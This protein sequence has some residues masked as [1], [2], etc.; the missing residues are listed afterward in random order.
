MPLDP[1]TPLTWRKLLAAVARRRLQQVLRPLR[2]TRLRRRRSG[3]PN[4]LI[5]AVDTLRYDHLGLAG[6]A[7]AATPAL[8]ALAASGTLFADVMAPA[9]WTLPSFTS[10]L[11]GVMP[12]LHGAGLPGAVRNMDTQP[13]RRLPPEVPTLAQ[14]LAGQ[15]YRTAAFYANPFF[16]FGL[17]ESFQVHAYANLPAT[18]LA[19]RALEW[20][21]RHGERP[22]F[23]FVLFN[24]PHEPTLP[25]ARH[26]RP[27]LTELA[28]RDIHP[29]GRQLRALARWGGGPHS[30][31]LGRTSTP[32]TREAEAALAIKLA[33][34]DAAVAAVDACVA[35][36]LR[37]LARWDLDAG[38]LV[39]VY[40]D[41]GEEFL[42]HAAAARLWNHDPRDIRAI[43]HGH[44]QFQELLHVPWLAAGPG[45]AAGVRRTEPVSLCDVAPT[46]AD[47]LG[48]AP[49]PLPTTSTPGLV[50]RSVTATGPEGGK[51][52]LLAEQ[53]AYG[54]DLVAVRR[55]RWKLL[56]P[57]QGEPLALFNLAEDRRERQDKR[58]EAPAALADLAA[59]LAVWR[60]AVPDG[61]AGPPAGGWQ[62]IS[63][64]V[65]RRLREL[66]YTG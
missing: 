52:L 46:L 42:D 27:F 32:L 44:S 34:Y 54:P 50:G 33:L 8:D 60:S 62:D 23:C 15:G 48:V 64:T 45:I 56:G 35:G 13:P 16:A 14:H 40:S 10:S 36:V 37:Q 6:H 30:I 47:W 22:F 4:L 65:R 49:F 57:R 7:H 20:I 63:E 5:L 28:V 66:G 55:G 39:T 1:F 3:P 19:F 17:A 51:R 12:G 38:T 21:R 2:P 24:D 26:L 11:T 25:P 43:G 58:Q 29:A 53:I 9:P 59:A 18:E 41:H 61:G 31:H